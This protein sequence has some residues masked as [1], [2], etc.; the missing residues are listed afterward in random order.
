MVVKPCA[1]L[2][3]LAIIFLAEGTN[4]R[5]WQQAYLMNDTP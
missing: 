2:P 4:G 1:P 3:F 5:T